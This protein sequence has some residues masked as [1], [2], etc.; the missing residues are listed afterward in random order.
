MGEGIIHIQNTQEDHDCCTQQS[1]HGP[2]EFFGNQ[3]RIDK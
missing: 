1:N 2:M 3:H